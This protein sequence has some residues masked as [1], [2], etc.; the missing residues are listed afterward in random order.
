M[1]KK[2]KLISKGITLAITL[3]VEVCTRG[4]VYEK[5][6]VFV[7]KTVTNGGMCEMMSKNCPRET[8]KVPKH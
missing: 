6:G 1:V 8:C 2:N 4:G 5:L 7:R 3:K